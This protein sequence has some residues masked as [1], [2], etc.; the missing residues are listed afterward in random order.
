MGINNNPKVND[1]SSLNRDAIIKRDLSF[2]QKCLIRIVKFLPFKDGINLLSASKEF[3]NNPALW[4][5]Y[6]EFQKKNS[7]LPK[8]NVLE[9]FIHSL[10]VENSTEEDSDNDQNTSK[11]N[12]ITPAPAFNVMVNRNSNFPPE[13]FMHIAG[14]LPFEDGINLLNASKKFRRNPFIWL[15][16]KEPMI[17]RFKKAG[18][19]LKEL[20][21]D[22]EKNKENIPSK[23]IF[24]GVRL[25]ANI[26]ISSFFVGGAT[27]GGVIALLAILASPDPVSLTAKVLGTLLFAFLGGSL[28]I[29]A[30]ILTIP[31]SFAS[32]GILGY[33]TG[34]CLKKK[35]QLDIKLTDNDIEKIKR[36]IEEL[37]DKE[38]GKSISHEILSPPP[39]SKINKKQPPNKTK[40]KGVSYKIKDIE[41]LEEIDKEFED[42]NIRV[43]KEKQEEVE[44]E[45]K[46]G[47]E[48]GEKRGGNNKVKAPPEVPKKSNEIFIFVPDMV[49]RQS[50]KT[51]FKKECER[52]QLTRRIFTQKE[53]KQINNNNFYFEKQKINFLLFEERLY[54][55]SYEDY[56]SRKGKYSTCVIKPVLSYNKK[57]GRRILGHSAQ[58]IPYF[59]KGFYEKR[60]LPEIENLEKKDV[61]FE[62]YDEKITPE[63]LEKYDKRKVYTKIPKKPFVESK[64]MD[65]DKSEEE[66][67]V[68][69]TT[70]SISAS[71]K[72]KRQLFIQ[73]FKGD[74]KNNNKETR[75]K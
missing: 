10:K 34:L 67:E 46:K 14:F 50:G 29:F 20:K 5:V 73:K 6:K 21:E 13:C 11:Y 54:E 12:I 27:I 37:K 28:G 56:R 4:L 70:V 35:V 36:K 33:I 18:K 7:E 42:Y 3:W 43:L 17:E 30:S 65:T 19:G 75:H 71:D 72:N 59:D 23:A 32:G 1:T 31:L 9:S 26:N 52:N 41:G 57:S 25:G 58:K 68:D 15:V 53:V 8:K 2:S 47:K 45:K 62:D 24:K 74:N 44:M 61:E 16:Y 64:T 48:E 38:L 69:T 49:Q 55:M 63:F 39:V 22:M 60:S 66:Q 51:K 40:K